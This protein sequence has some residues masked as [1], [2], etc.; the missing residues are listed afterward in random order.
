MVAPLLV[1]V[2]AGC[3]SPGA[4][5]RN[6]GTRGEVRETHAQAAP[7]A[8]VQELEASVFFRELKVERPS[9]SMRVWL[10][11]PRRE[12][13]KPIGCVVVPPAGS[14]LVSGMRLSRGDRREHLPYVKAGYV[15][16]SFDIDGPM[17]DGV[18]EAE[19]IRS[20]KIFRASEAGVE[21]GEAAL[22]VALKAFPTIDGRR[23]YAAGHS[24]AATLALLLAAR[25]ERIKAV[26]AF[27]PVTDLVS[28]FPLRARL[29]LDRA[30]PGY[31][32]F[33][34]ASSP[35]T[36]A[37]TLAAKPVFLFHARD[38]ETV[39][40]EQSER[41]F[42]A[43]SPRHRASRRVVVESG[44]HSEAMIHDGIPGAIA[45]FAQLDE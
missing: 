13:S 31:G 6:G 4:A 36:Y 29:E 3:N 18:S 22:D 37:S 23:I 28:L 39:K 14:N 27:A 35:I 44:G 5:E 41:L 42:A 16:V 20:M 1:V 19:A 34:A 2:V 10:Y 17:S 30:L 33:L 15:V 45:W 7:V 12:V 38:D 26:A 11:A 25:D 24:S 9:C 43:M 8:G 21:N 40:P 32:E